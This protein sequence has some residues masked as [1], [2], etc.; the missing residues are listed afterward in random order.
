MEQSGVL[1]YLRKV[2]L[3]H[4]RGNA[5]EVCS[6]AGDYGIGV[7]PII[8]AF[9]LCGA[10]MGASLILVVI[11]WCVGRK[12]KRADFLQAKTSLGHAGRSA[13]I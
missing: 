12:S 7:R 6:I 9:V 4:E 1:N 3:I 2:H 10:G 11:E 5:D 8:L 13:S